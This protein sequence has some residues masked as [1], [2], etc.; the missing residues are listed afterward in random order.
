MTKTVDIQDVLNLLDL[1]SFS[2]DV[3]RRVYLEEP[4]KL[5]MEEFLKGLIDDFPF[6]KENIHIQNGIIDIKK[7]VEKFQMDK[8]FDNL[9]WD[10]TRLFIGPYQ[11][12]APIWESV[13]LNKHGVLFQEETMRV[14]KMYLDYNLVSKQKGYEAEDHL[15]FELDFMYQLVEIAKEKI[16]DKEWGEAYQVLL[17]QKHFLQCH[18]LEWAPLFAKNVVTHANTEFYRGTAQLLVG[19][20]KIDL[21]CVNDLLENL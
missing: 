5:L 18:L 7:Y 2:Y 16:K 13:Y 12:K 15:G 1:R 14:R 8:D 3:L 9:H 11:V 21:L 10:Y 6:T 19:Y 17:H 20:L 4:S